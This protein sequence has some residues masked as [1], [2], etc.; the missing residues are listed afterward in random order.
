MAH[1]QIVSAKHVLN[2]VLELQRRGSDVVVKELESIEP[3]L[4]EYVMETSCQIHR[5][6]MRNGLPNRRALRLYRQTESIALVCVM[7]L[8][9]AHFDLWRE[10]HGDHPSSDEPT[11]SGPDDPA[12]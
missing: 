1:D 5:Q 6:L 10:S 4:A 8:R 12:H 9:Q 3:D 2:A 11:S 7:A